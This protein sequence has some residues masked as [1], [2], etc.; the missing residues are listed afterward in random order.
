MDELLKATTK[1]LAR[2]LEDV[3]P[4]VSPHDWWRSRV[5]EQLN[6]QQRAFVI[7][8]GFKSLHHLDL[9]ALIQVLDRNWR[10]IKSIQ[11]LPFDTLNYLKEMRSVRNRWAH[12]SANGINVDD[13][14][15][16]LD[17]LGRFLQALD[18]DEALLMQVKAAK[19]LIREKL[20]HLDRNIAEDSRPSEAHTQAPSSSGATTAHHDA[21]KGVGLR[22][23][24]SKPKAKSPDSGAGMTAPQAGLPSKEQYRI[25]CEA[26]DEAGGSLLLPQ[27]Y[28]VVERKFPPGAFL[29]SQ[30]KASL[31]EVINRQ[32]TRAGLVE[33]DESY[34]GLWRITPAGRAY[35]RE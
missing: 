9:A 8:R 22:P 6:E 15:R 7:E 28:E 1:H 14:W 16:D 11:A 33:Q 29:S 27:I 32:M 24:I 35:W 30:G 5:F 4:L 21:E 26:L 34:L 2:Y 31:R 18:A 25:I 3:L 20:A 17:T 19:D 23:R 13:H 10:E 12:L